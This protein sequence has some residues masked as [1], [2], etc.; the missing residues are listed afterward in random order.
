[1]AP[2]SDH[3]STRR[4]EPAGQVL[5]IFPHDNC[6]WHAASKGDLAAR[7]AAFLLML[8]N[9]RDVIDVHANLVSM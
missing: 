9:C 3:T 4:T 5:L 1:M 8:S 2:S 7:S 6:A